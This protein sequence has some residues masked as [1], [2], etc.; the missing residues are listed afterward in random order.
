[1]KLN[2]KLYYLT[3]DYSAFFQ[4][5]GV[6]FKDVSAFGKCIN[7]LIANSFFKKRSRMFFRFSSFKSGYSNLLTPI[8]LGLFIKTN[9]N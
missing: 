9:C 4:E 3:L 6:R 5:P 7:V 1:M 8:A 2:C